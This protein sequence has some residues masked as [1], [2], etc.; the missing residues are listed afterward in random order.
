MTRIKLWLAA[1]AAGFAALAAWGRAQRKRGA[2]EAISDIKE[3]D[4]ERATSIRDRTER[5]HSDRMR[6]FVSRGYRD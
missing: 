5:E 4:Y 3:R 1:L 2:V 6:E